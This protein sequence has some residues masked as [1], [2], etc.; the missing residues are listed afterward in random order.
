MRAV[1]V[2]VSITV[3]PPITWPVMTERSEKS[4]K[5]C[6]SMLSHSFKVS[7]SAFGRS[8]FLMERARLSLSCAHERKQKRFRG[9]AD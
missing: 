1:F 5:G 4:D 9:G 2:I 7:G 6:E 3:P 8:D